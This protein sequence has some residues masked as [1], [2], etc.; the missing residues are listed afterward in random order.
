ML[1]SEDLGPIKK[2]TEPGLFPRQV[3]PRLYPNGKKPATSSEIITP[4]VQR[5][6]DAS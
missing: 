1:L 3:D 2:R 5:S 4:L 6:D